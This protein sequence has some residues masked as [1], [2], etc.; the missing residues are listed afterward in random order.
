MLG[1]WAPGS[2]MA[3]QH[4]R[5]V[6]SAE[7][8]LT[9]STLNRVEGGW[10]PAHA[11]DAPRGPVEQGGDAPLESPSAGESPE[12]TQRIIADRRWRDIACL[13]EGELS[14]TQAAT[15]QKIEEGPTTHR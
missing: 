8:K 15:S 6:C 4:R 13:S 9:D 10:R 3:E 5:A 11:F 7:L 12:T 1:H 2:D 14:P